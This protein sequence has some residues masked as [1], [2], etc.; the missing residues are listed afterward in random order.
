M[1]IGSSALDVPRIGLGGMRLSLHYRP[2]E[3]EAIEVLLT[4]VNVGVRFIDTANAYCLTMKD[5]GHNERLISKALAL[6]S[7]R[8]R[9]QVVVATKGGINRPEGDWVR[10]GRPSS[11]RKACEKSLSDLGMESIPLYQLHAPDPKISF[12]DQVGTLDELKKEGKI[13]NVDSQT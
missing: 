13:Q 11:L 2:S 7:P 3:K 12:E 10:D 9:K 5:A 6:L 8:V 4:A 1:K